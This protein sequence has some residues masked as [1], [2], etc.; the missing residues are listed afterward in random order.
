MGL[1]EGLLVQ[2]W[3]VS[4]FFSLVVGQTIAQETDILKE[5]H[6]HCTRRGKNMFYYL[7]YIL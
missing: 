2:I 6:H 7:I 3:L 1:M 4:Y 5:H